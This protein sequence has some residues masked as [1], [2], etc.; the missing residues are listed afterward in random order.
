MTRQLLVIFNDRGT[1]PHEFVDGRRVWVHQIEVNTVLAS[2]DSGT[3]WKY[4]A[5]S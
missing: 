2:F 4:Q 1:E 3:L 5:G